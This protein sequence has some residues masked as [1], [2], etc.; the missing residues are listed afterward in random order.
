MIEYYGHHGCKQFIRG[1]P[2]RFVYK[3]WCLN[4]KNGY[5]ANFEV[6][7][8]KQKDRGTSPQYKKE[9]GKASAP[10]LEMVYELPVDVRDLPYHFYFDNLFT[11]LQLVRH[12]KDKTMK[13]QAQ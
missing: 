12:L 1:N 4:S 11:S 13:P 3:V 7:Q 8:G 9:F 2:I 5:L 10:L 6:Y